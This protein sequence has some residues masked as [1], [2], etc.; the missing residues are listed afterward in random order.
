MNAKQ[1][2]AFHKELKKFQNKYPECAITAWMPD[3]FQDRASKKLTKEDN[4][5]IAEE[6]VNSFDAEIGINWDVIDNVM[7]DLDLSGHGLII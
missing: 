3:D 1:E 7:G 5:N 6:L 4:L 2:K